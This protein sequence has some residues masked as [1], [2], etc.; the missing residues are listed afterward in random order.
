M[1]AKK[2]AHTANPATRSR[3]SPQ[4]AP[5]VQDVAKL[6]KVSV[7]SVSRVLNG[8]ANVAP[9][10]QEAV[11]KAVAQLNF[12][13]NV[14]ARSMRKGSSKAIGCLIS[15]IAQHTAAQMVSA[16][17]ARLREHGYEILIANSHY[18]LERERAILESLK[19]R[20]L[21]GFIGAI[22]DDETPA[23]FNLLRT[24]NMPVVLWERDAQGEFNSVLTDHADGCRQAVRYLTSLGHRRI[25][26]VAGHEHTWV[27]REMVR[28][29]TAACEDAGIGADPAL[30]LRTGEFG[31][32]ACR[33]LLGG[34]ARPSAIIATLNDTATVL[35]VVRDLGLIVPGDLSVVSIGDHQYAGI[36]APA[37]TVVTQDPRA[38]GTEAADMMLQLL[39][40]A[41]PSGIRRSKHPMRM[42]IRESCAAPAGQPKRGRSRAA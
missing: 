6:A 12:V 20:R 32:D 1:P 14:V 29:Y 3:K 37:L 38:V 23:Y 28:G 31:E 30:I 42:I 34:A 9:E 18:D 36:S 39:E 27:G 22:S 13:P 16:A 11:R 24:L 5:T 8:R 26:L 15:D 41:G 4:G 17:E 40:G 25:A 19:Q 10:I 21:D 2:P 35:E 7:G 33:S